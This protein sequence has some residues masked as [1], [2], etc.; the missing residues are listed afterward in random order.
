MEIVATIGGWGVAIVLAVIALFPK[1]G[2]LEHQ[3]IDQQQKRVQS[4]E[5]RVDKLEPL[6]RWHNS[7][8]VAWERRE[9]QLM[10]GVERGE[11]PP[12]PEREGILTEDAP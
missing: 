12:W 1:K 3:M 2:A 4:L 5:E 8:D 6:L 10:G 9:A 7:R 11:Y